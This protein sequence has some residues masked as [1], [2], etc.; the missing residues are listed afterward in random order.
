[1]TTETE[2]DY[3][4]ATD[5]EIRLA[6]TWVAG[7]TADWNEDDDIDAAREVEYENALEIIV[8]ANGGRTSPPRPP[9]VVLCGS[10]RFGDAFREANLR[11]T[12]A[13]RIVLSIGCDT[14][15]DSELWSDPDEAARI[16]AELDE[17]HKR[18]I[19]M[20][21]EVL[22]VSDESGYFG[23]S[24]RSEVAYARAQDKPVRFA[25]PAAEERWNA[26]A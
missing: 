15:A 11:E 3:R 20:A 6:K 22:V 24:T 8:H 10:T 26:L 12:L 21:D 9:V 1:M 7:Y 23:E 25:H 16:K 19:D 13:G 14:R 2:T 18:K 4:R 17:L 5:R